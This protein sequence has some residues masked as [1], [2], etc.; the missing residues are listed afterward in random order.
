MSDNTPEEVGNEICRVHEFIFNCPLEG[1]SE[2]EAVWSFQ[3]A[4]DAVSN[5]FKT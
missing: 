4:L 5:I 2:E 1:E 3:K